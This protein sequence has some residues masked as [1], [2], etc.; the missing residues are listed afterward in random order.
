MSLFDYCSDAGG[1]FKCRMADGT[2][3]VD[4]VVDKQTRG[5]VGAITQVR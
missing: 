5:N 1:G 2:E 4:V 3:S